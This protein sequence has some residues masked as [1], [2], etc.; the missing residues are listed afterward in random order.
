M[1]K[2]AVFVSRETS[3]KNVINV[4][5]ETKP[6]NRATKKFVSRETVNFFRK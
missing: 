1:Q 4:S 6:K 5:R 2:S 3:G